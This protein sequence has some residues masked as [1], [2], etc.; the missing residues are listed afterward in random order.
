VAQPAWLAYGF[1]AVMAWVSGFCTVRLALARRL[2]RQTHYDVNLSHVLM[3]VAMI[4]MLVPRWNGIP[5]GFWEIVFAVIA[6]YFV[7][8]SVRFVAV[9]GLRGI[10]D[11][12]VHHISH[13][14]IHA[15]LACAMLYMYW[16]G[17]PITTMSGTSMSMS[18]PPHGVGDPG[19]TLF[20]I[21]ILV[22]SAVWQLESIGEFARQPRVAVGAGGAAM[23]GAIG[24]AP[25]GD[26]DRPWLAPRLEIGDHIAMC[27]T[28][29][30]VL[31]LMV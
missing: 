10:D 6:L 14:L 23:G 9:H 11:D 31:V 19:L 4:G 28:M 30:Y 29:A 18:G 5:S 20:L 13:Y 27:I 12:H 22:A 3:G 7:A 21:T 25:E 17:M 2:G 1:C 16:L 26:D 15:V 24:K 8:L